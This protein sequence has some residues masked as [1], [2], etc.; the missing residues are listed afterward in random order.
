[1]LSANAKR[2]L[3]IVV[4]SLLFFTIAA[5]ASQ[6]V[7]KHQFGKPVCDGDECSIVLSNQF[8][9]SKNLCDASSAKTVYWNRQ[10]P[11]YL[12][13]CD[14]DCSMQKNVN[15]IIDKKRSRVYGFSYGRYVKK[16]YVETAAVETAVPERF[17]SVRFSA[18]T[19]PDKIRSSIFV[20]LNKL[21]SDMV[22]PYCYEVTYIKEG[23]GDLTV[24]GDSGVVPKNNHD[25]WIWNIAREKK[26][27]L[28]AIVNAIQ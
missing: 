6:P 22:S 4:V 18:A 11:Y 7:K 28:L 20:L 3:L 13:Q 23:G 25:Y 1:M 8:D 10:R 26:S 15:W 16:S 5:F 17:A 12:I 2:S 9:A 21:P 19:Q 27:I 14:C 24:S